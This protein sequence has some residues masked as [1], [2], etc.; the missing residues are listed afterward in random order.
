[1]AEV[2][3]QLSDIYTKIG[4]NTMVRSYPSVAQQNIGNEIQNKTKNLIVIKP[5]I[6]T[7][8][9]NQTIK[10]AEKIVNSNKLKVGVKRIKSVSKGAILLECDDRQ[11]METFINKINENSTEIIAA[12]PK[13]Q[14]PKIVIKGVS[15]DVKGEELIKTIIE[16]IGDY[17]ETSSEEDIEKEL[18]IKFKF[19]RKHNSSEN[20]CVL[21]I[22]PK[23][24]DEVFRKL[25]KIRI[26]WKI[27][28]FETY[29]NIIHCFKCNGFG[30]ITKVCAQ[31]DSCGHC[32]QTV[33]KTNAYTQPKSSHFCTNCDRYNK[34]TKTSMLSTT[35]STFSEN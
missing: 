19:R 33:H 9:C 16:T 5:I 35:H 32:G 34:K 11:E 23:L 7:I 13:T 26:G 31:Q 14:T 29:I 1:M 2:K 28:S 15:G 17:F 8:D 6:E 30:H 27:H 21:E 25:N 3:Q 20:T 4:T 10:M 24:R 12:K 22:S 18:K